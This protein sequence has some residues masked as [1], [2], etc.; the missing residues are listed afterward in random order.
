MALASIESTSCLIGIVIGFLLF[1][2][3][4]LHDRIICV[5]RALTS[6][7]SASCLILAIDSVCNT[8]ALASIESTNCLNPLT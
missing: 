4:A 8:P 5:V 6:I 7:E 1:D 2:S 3:K